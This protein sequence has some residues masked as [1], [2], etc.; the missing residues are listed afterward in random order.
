MKKNLLIILLLVANIALITL[1]IV[2][3]NNRDRLRPELFSTR[4]DNY[5]LVVLDTKK[6]D[7]TID[8]SRNFQI[9]N[10]NNGL[11]R[12]TFPRDDVYQYFIKDWVVKDS[13]LIPTDSCAY[14]YIKIPR[15]EGYQNP[16]DLICSSTST[17]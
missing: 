7:Y 11:I 6:F 15:V 8:N 1:T 14:L 13:K 10:A 12:Y 2:N 3:I 17:I 5:V 16:K 4:M 9:A